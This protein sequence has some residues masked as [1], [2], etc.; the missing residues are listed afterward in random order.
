[1]STPMPSVSAL[2]VYPLKSARGVALDT[3]E[4]DDHGARDDRRWMAVDENG[5][6]LSQRSVPALALL[7]PCLMPAGLLLSA[8]GM[9]PIAVPRPD[10]GA[11][12]VAIEGRVRGSAV[13]VLYEPQ[14]PQGAELASFRTLWLFPVV[15]SIFGLP[16]LGAGLFGLL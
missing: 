6:V 13:R 15:T 4:L 9:P 16:F 11:G 3:M 7:Q 10:S 2:Y 14:R 8:P 5:R 12:A 1:M